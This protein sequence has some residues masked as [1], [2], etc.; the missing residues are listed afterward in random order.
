M[1]KII[2][3]L[4]AA[5]CSNVLWAQTTFTVGNIS[6]V[7]IDSNAV[8]I[9]NYSDSDSVLAIPSVVTNQCTSY[10]VREIG[11]SAFYLS[12]SLRYV[13]IPNT[14][15]IIGDNAFYH[16]KNLYSVTLPDSLTYIGNSAFEYCRN[17]TS[18]NIPNTLT[19]ILFRTF[20]STGLTSLTLPNS[21]KTIGSG[22]FSCCDSL[23][24]LVI[25]GSITSLES[26][27]FSNC[28]NLQS[29]TFN[30]SVN[31]IGSSVFQNCSSL[32]SVVLPES[33]TSIPTGMFSDCTNLTS[34]IIPDN[35]VSIGIGAFYNCHNLSSI[36]IPNGVR[37]IKRAAFW[38]CISLTSITLP[39]SLTTIEYGAFAN[40]GLLSIDIPDNVTNMGFNVFESCRNL[41]FVS[42]PAGCTFINWCL[43]LDCSSLDSIYIPNTVTSI[44][45]NAFEN[46]TSL[47]SIIIPENVTSIGAWAFLNCINLQEVVSLA[48]T[49]PMI[50]SECFEHISDTAVLKVRCNINGYSSS[51]WNS[52][53]DTIQKT[54]SSIFHVAANVNNEDWGYV[55][56][57]GNCTDTVRI[58]AIANDCYQFQSWNDGNTD[59]PRIISLRRDTSYTAIFDLDD[60]NNINIYDTICQGEKYTENNF[61]ANRT[62]IYTRRLISSTGCDSIVTLHLTVNQHTTATDIIEACDSL[63]WIDSITYTEST[64]QPTYRLTNSGDCDSIVTLNLTIK[65]SSNTIDTYEVC[66]SLTW[67][68]GITYYESTDTPTYIYTAANGCDSI[69][70]LNLTINSYHITDTVVAC[71]SYTWID[72]ITYTESTDSPTQTYTALSGCDS[73]ITLNL[74]INHSVYDIVVDTA[75]NEYVWNDT[76]YIESGI[77]YY[78]GE[79]SDGCDSVV[80]LI[81]TIEE[82]GI[83]TANELDQL[84]L[85]PNPTNGTITFN[86][87]D[88]RKVEVM[89]AVGRMVAL[90][91]DSYIIDL[92]KLSKGYYTLRVTTDRGVAIRKVIRN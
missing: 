16:C 92:S 32:T 49:P 91:N 51:A 41:T 53:F 28:S 46:C 65:H 59:N 63:I 61:Y 54:D 35:V 31:S 24:S 14:V 74:T 2:T 57:E 78:Y 30:D 23:T 71:D 37:R 84:R 25:L 22:A 50:N 6:Y 68:D 45:N 3:L 64:N 33:I 9:Y 87:T 21:I 4:C 36:N 55:E 7:V 77:Y 90:Y 34:I 85:Y 12:D 73:I 56:I 1:K 88:I 15:T 72:G 81:L 8:K 11:E 29:V 86:T 10:T 13:T 47:S 62:G 75:V 89:D 70:T 38:S 42:L 18:I 58:T 83:E 5:L 19:N 48:Q 79:T 60:N 66:D 44:H 43:F 82:I 69:I 52:Y 76:T 67:I 80:T 40:S 26:N 20:Y 39:D 27:A 17:L